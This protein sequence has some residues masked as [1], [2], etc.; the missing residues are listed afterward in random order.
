MDNCERFDD[1]SKAEEFIKELKAGKESAFNR[2]IEE[3]QK[4]V[5]RIALSLV[6]NP[7]DAE[8]IA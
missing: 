2:L 5:Y 3:N 8:D 6:K 7:T 4:K 1:T